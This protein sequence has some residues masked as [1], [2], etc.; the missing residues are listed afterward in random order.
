MIKPE[1]GLYINE[2]FL[3][4]NDTSGETAQDY[5]SL[6]YNDETKYILSHRLARGHSAICIVTKKVV[7]GAE[8]E[9]GT[10]KILMDFINTE[11]TAI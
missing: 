11:R 2:P 5:L 8:Y 1:T 6:Q 7:T 9:D 10:I 4:K 3:I